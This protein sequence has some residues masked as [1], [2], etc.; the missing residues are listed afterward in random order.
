MKNHLAMAVG[1]KPRHFQAYLHKIERALKRGDAT[2]HTHRP[3]LKELL[4]ALDDKITATNEPKRSNCGA[5]DYVISRKRDQLTL[6]YVEAKM[7]GKDL[8]EIE[9]NE[10]LDRYLA[11][12]T[13]LLLTDYLEFR[14]F[15]DGEQRGTFRIARVLPGG[16][17]APVAPDE[18]E[19]ARHFLL[20]FLSQKPVD[21]ASA[22]ELARRLANLTHNIRNIITGAFLTGQASQQLRDWRAAFAA[23]LLPELAP[24]TDA[25]NGKPPP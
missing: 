8:E 13:N 16:K 25:G 3:A 11:S 9:H 10:Q 14:W 17:L 23:T 12:L 2:E 24:N 5:P 1:P 15:V 18:I 21:I 22:E 4:E 7:S 19:R 6:G 20:G